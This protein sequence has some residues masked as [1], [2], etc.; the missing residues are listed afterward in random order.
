M[1]VKQCDICGKVIRDYNGK[2]YE[3]CITEYA[4]V[5]P[6][7]EQ[8]DVCTECKNKILSMREVH[9]NDD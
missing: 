1:T 2:C 8:F 9:T 4:F 6:K 5:L 3:V 7:S